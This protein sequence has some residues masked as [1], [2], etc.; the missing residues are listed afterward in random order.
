[1]IVSS[2]G[3]YLPLSAHDH[4]N[5]HVSPPIPATQQN[6]MQFQAASP[7]NQFAKLHTV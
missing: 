1:M 4:E 7:L 5:V 6:C 2:S 3:R